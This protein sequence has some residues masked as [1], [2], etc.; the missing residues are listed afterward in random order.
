M[1]L[2]N[3]VLNLAHPIVFLAMAV[4]VAWGII[5]GALPGLGATL[6]IALLIPF[7]Y[8][9]DPNVA[10]PMLAGVYAGSIYGGGITAILLGVPGT[11]ADAATVF[12]GH[13]MAKKGMAN[14]ALTASVT[15]SAVGGM[16][17][18]LA[19]LLLAPPLAR[20]SLAFG[21]HEYFLI[22]IFGL[23]VIAAL[24]P[25]SI[26]LGLMG[27]ALGLLLG[28]VGIDPIVGD[29]RYT[30]GQ[31][32][33]YDGLPLI[34][35]LLGLF[36]F[37]RALELG[38]DVIQGRAKTLS[39][40]GSSSNG[41]PKISWAEMWSSRRTYI[42][43]SLLG[44]LIGIIPGAGANIA[45]FVG[46]AAAKRASKDPRSFGTGNPDG[47]IASESSNNGTCSA[48]LVPL[49]TLSLPGSP[50]AAV[51]LGALMIHGM[52]PGAELFT[53]HAETTYTFIAAGFF[54]N[55]I[56]LGMGWY[57]SRWF[58]SIVRIPT[59][60]LAPAMLLIAFVGAY[61]A[62]QQVFDI[63]LMVTIGLVAIWLAKVGVPIAAVLLGAIL[64][65]M[66][67]AGLRRAMVISGGDPLSFFTR[68]LSVVLIILTVLA[69]FAGWQMTKRM[70]VLEESVS[71]EKS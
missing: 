5:C 18:A 62:R 20:F 31:V 71:V 45:C 34:P 12:D 27:G 24:A 60:I 55:V 2:L 10:L 57:G 17:S 33:L 49:L 22:A 42:R 68:P 40:A 54:C 44:T 13:P 6:G 9:V 70:K 4:G 1:D 69:I 19:L 61:A 15:A 26:I 59:A 53:R 11:S 64:G 16:I 35:M 48:S 38:L 28:T 29:M 41:G 32:P 66:A 7:T 65:P 51:I 23:T 43:S 58:G 63:G 30:F 36:A 3:G 47:V 67:E 37:P 56:M 46:Y 25:T 50:T 21:P 14:K 8:G 52:T 39:S